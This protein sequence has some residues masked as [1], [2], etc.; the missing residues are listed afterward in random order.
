M[1]LFHMISFFTTM[2]VW[3]F[4][5]ELI[6]SHLIDDKGYNISRF[7]EWNPL[8]PLGLFELLDNDKILNLIAL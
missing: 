6:I 7:W 3:I 1:T 4:I 5:G 8:W 2:I